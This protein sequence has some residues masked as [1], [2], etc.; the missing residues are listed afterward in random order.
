MIKVRHNNYRDCQLLSKVNIGENLLLLVK[1]PNP[2]YRLKPTYF[3]YWSNAKSNV[4][5]AGRE[6]IRTP[7]GRKVSQKTAIKK[8]LEM[9]EASKYLQFSS[10]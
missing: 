1:D 4:E 10:L 2:G 5:Q 3:V 6:E 9:V 8:F 7:T